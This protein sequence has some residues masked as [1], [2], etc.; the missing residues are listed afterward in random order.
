M[1]DFPYALIQ[2]ARSRKDPLGPQT[3]NQLQLN[4]VAL[5]ELARVEHFADGQHNALEVPWV[6]GHLDDGAPPTGYLLDTAYGGGTL[7]RP[8]TGRYTCSV[9]AGVVKTAPDGSLVYS[10]MANV[11]DPAIE[12]KPHT[13]TVEAVSATSFQFRVRQLSSA[14]GAGDTWA[15]Q[16]SDIDIG[17]HSLQD[18]G[19][20]SLIGS[21]LQKVQGDTLTD[22]AADWNALVVN[23]AII[24]KAS[25]L[26]HTSGGLHR[27]NRIAKAVGF[28]TSSGGYSAAVEQGVASVAAVSTG[29]VEVT[30]DDNFTSTNT[31]A[32]F[33]EVQPATTEEL[34][35]INGR[36]FATGAGTST[37]RF[38]IYAFDGVNWA[39]A[40]RSFFASMFGVVA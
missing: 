30:M 27:A 4:A 23:Q 13:I 8:A 38:Y 26:E 6:L 12:S 11:S 9:I 1:A 21:Y 31:M 28:F 36:G 18:S 22:Q 32:C 25:L 35:I 2:P 16:N 10:T 17:L 37:F 24:R 7:A 33:P 39:R 3:L 40:D 5:D 20:V 19:D 14:L 15:D 34:V 29:V